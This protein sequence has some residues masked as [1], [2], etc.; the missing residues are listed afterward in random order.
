M[1]DAT[2]EKQGGQTE[3]RFQTFS[4]LQL[5]HLFVIF[6]GLEKRHF[7]QKF[8]GYKEFFLSPR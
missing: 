7:K 4:S 6:V 5:E 2:L 1:V 3:P 8:C